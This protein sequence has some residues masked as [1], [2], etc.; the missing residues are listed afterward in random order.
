MYIHV[1]CAHGQERGFLERPES[2]MEQLLSYTQN[3]Q[4]AT[5]AAVPG[6]LDLKSWPLELGL[7]RLRQNA[8]LPGRS[9]FFFVCV[10]SWWLFSLLVFCL[11]FACV[12]L[13]VFFFLLPLGLGLSF[14]L[15]VLGWVCYRFGPPL[16]FG[17]LSFL[18]LLHDQCCVSFRITR[19]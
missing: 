9:P 19:N 13:R 5:G 6:R 8:A 15:L 4:Q 10:L 7:E 17:K 16:F 14:C 3:L 11:F 12:C 18:C 1:Y 2:V